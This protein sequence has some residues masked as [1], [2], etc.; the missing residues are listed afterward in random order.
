MDKLRTSALKKEI[1]TQ[2]MLYVTIDSIEPGDKRVVFKCHHVTSGGGIT[3]DFTKDKEAYDNC[4]GMIEEGCTY[5]I[6]QTLVSHQYGGRWVWSGCR[7]CT[8]NQAKHI[9]GMIGFKDVTIDKL[10]GA[11]EWLK[12]VEKPVK[13]PNLADELLEF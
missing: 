9:A 5:I 1:G 3:H 8:P 12:A 6:V 13:K 11:I 2:E 7:L 4:Y 10:R